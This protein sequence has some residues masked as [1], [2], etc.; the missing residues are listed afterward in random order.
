MHNLYTQVYTRSQPA[1]DTG[2]KRSYYIYLIVTAIAVRSGILTFSA[3]GL[4]IG[5]A[6]VVH[7][8]RIGVQCPYTQYH[9]RGKTAVFITGLETEEIELPYSR[10]LQ[11]V[12]LEAEVAGLLIAVVAIAVFIAQLGIRQ[13]YA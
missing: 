10:C 11:Y 8:K 13:A 2:T 12:I 1:F 7:H 5:L 6:A 9:I 3:Q 4:Q